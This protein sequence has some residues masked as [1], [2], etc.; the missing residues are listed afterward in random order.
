[1]P[2]F[3]LLK[4]RCIAPIGRSGRI[5][6]KHELIDKW[7]DDPYIS[8]IG[9]RA[10]H[11]KEFYYRVTGHDFEYGD[12]PNTGELRKLDKKITRLQ[13]SLRKGPRGVI[14]KWF[15][16]PEEILNKNPITKKIFDGLSRAHNYFRGHTDRNEGDLTTLTKQLRD[17]AGTLQKGNE[18]Q[19]SFNKARKELLQD[20]ADY[21]T[22]VANG[23]NDLAIQKKTEIHGS[24]KEGERVVFRLAD[25]LF[26][27]PKLLETKEGA[28]KY[29]LLEPALNTWKKMSRYLYRD[30]ESGLNS[31]IQV[32]KMSANANNDMAGV[33]GRIEK[34]RDTLLKRKNYLP[35]QALDVFPMFSA[36]TELL[37]EGKWYSGKDGELME[38][39]RNMTNIAE[40]NIRPSGHIWPQSQRDPEFSDYSKDIV[41]V[42]DTYAKNVA[43]FNLYGKATTEFIGGVQKLATLEGTVLEKQA[44]W[45]ADYLFDTHKSLLGF[46]AKSQ[47]VV[48]LARMVTAWQFISKL[49]LNQRTALRNATQSL[50]NFTYF[51]VKGVMDATSF[52]RGSGL[53]D[54][55]NAEQKKHGLFFKA[56]RELA[57]P[58]A[59]FPQAK[60]REVDGKEVYYYDSNTFGAKFSEKLEQAARISGWGMQVVENRLNRNWT[61]KIAFGTLYKELSTNRGTIERTLSKGI[62][63]GKSEKELSKDVE[64]EI[65]K[66]SSRFA[67]NMVRHLH[68]EYSPFAKPKALRTPVGAIMGQF[69]TYSINFFNF[70]KNIALDAKDEVMSGYWGEGANRAMF[71]SSIYFIT[72]AIVSP[73]FNADISSLIQHDTYERLEALYEY[74]TAEDPEDKRKAFFGKG[75]IIGTFGGPAIS[76]IITIGNIIGLYKLNDTEWWSMLMGYQDWSEETG[77]KKVAEVARVLNTQLYRAGWIVRPRIWEGG[78]VMTQWGYDLTGAYPS[79]KLYERKEWIGEHIPG[80]KA[81]GFQ[82][83]GS[84]KR[85]RDKLLNV[86][87]S[88]G[89]RKKT[90]ILEALERIS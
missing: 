72:E 84:K 64:N 17:A 86:G 66:K 46:G 39:A 32:L 36:M 21:S 88:P 52:I 33:A 35:V 49:G 56:P 70:N 24:L 60:V 22:L 45:M 77:D 69:A 61:F 48:N 25:E 8:A 74:M 9:N 59:I 73:Y 50:H 54:I 83:S 3:T 53:N 57:Q 28:A 90:K 34:L 1:M 65:I 23:E 10:K 27:N 6:K 43:R 18:K 41:S 4:G 79:K 82:E 67:A 16:L 2:G 42:V 89:V 11:F 26:R 81:I 62:S 80:A 14:P 31:Y 55:V 58:F 40:G 7:Y 44:A 47:R 78:N 71:L 37:Y 5:T 38:M 51:G 13:K 12:L 68:Y 87:K 19:I 85:R 75:P 30:L 63:K 20:Y 76:D 15:Y 29:G